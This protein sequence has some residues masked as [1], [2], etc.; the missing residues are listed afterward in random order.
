LALRV[1]NPIA[2][3]KLMS[4]YYGRSDL[5]AEFYDKHLFGGAKFGDLAKSGGRPYLAINATDMATGEH[6]VF[7]YPRFGL[8]A[9]DINQFPIAR[10]VAASSA[11]PLVLTPMTIRNYA[12][13]PGA[14][15]PHF[16]P[17]ATVD[18][19]QVSHR[20]TQ[21]L[22]FLNSYADS[23]SKPYLHL[24]DGG[25]A[26]NLGMQSLIDDTIAVG[27]A[28]R[29]MELS[30]MQRPKRL[31][32]IEVNSAAS[33]GEEWNRR[34]AVPG[35]ITS[36][37]ALG[38]RS[39]ERADYQTVEAFR[40]ALE[41][42]KRSEREA[43]HTLG[44]SPDYYFIQVAFNAIANASERSYFRNLMTTFNLPDSTVDRLVA[45][46][47]KVLRESPEF[48]RLLADLKANH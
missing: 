24:V 37:L 21:V 42:W 7:S 27:G 32:I 23:K 13:M 33:R 29:L 46:G 6:F 31:V 38:D 1:L 11:I 40:D 43:H 22:G 26:D 28:S 41:S 16:V 39:G 25:L 15:Q 34:E 30:G 36:I 14:A 45:A 4:P 10:A 44:D 20:E 19:R 18:D 9:S 12:G 48:K 2:W 5:A 17:R 3:P 47:G 35:P 8:I